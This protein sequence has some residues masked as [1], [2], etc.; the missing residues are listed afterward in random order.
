MTVRVA[1]PHDDRFRDLRRAR[2]GLEKVAVVRV[3][4]PRHEA[5]IRVE[6]ARRV[7]EH[8]LDRRTHILEGRGWEDSIA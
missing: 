6:R 1:Q 2:I 3:D 4:Q 7:S 5:G 8:G